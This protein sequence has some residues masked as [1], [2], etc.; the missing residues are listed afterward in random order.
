M[1][2]TWEDDVRCHDLGGN[3]GSLP[4]GSGLIT[5]TMVDILFGACILKGVILF[6]SVDSALAV[7][8]FS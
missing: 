7:A 6:R 4:F 3:D 8:T 1:L 2:Q 5:A